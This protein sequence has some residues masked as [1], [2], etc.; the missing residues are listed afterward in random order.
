MKRFV[1]SGI[2]VAL[3]ALTYAAL[4][5][6]TTGREPSFALEW[7]MVVAAA[8]WFMALAAS[9]LRRRISGL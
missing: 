2:S 1:L 6:I 7:S 5:D 8:I 4:D 3:L 9:A